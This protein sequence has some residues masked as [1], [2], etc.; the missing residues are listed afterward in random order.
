[1][2]ESVKGYDQIL[3]DVLAGMRHCRRFPQ[4]EAHAAERATRLGD[5]HDAANA[6]TDDTPL[7]VAKWMSGCR[8][9]SIGRSPA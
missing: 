7:T 4:K 1:M 6:T 3:P 9:P 5:E 2:M 8:Y